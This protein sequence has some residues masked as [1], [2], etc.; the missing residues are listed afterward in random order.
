MGKSIANLHRAGDEFVVDFQ[1][2]NGSLGLLFFPGKCI[3]MFGIDLNVPYRIF[4]ISGV[5]FDI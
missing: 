5:F 1:R 4:F 2:A 3:E